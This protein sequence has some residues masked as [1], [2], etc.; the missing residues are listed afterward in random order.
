M[1]QQEIAKAQLEASMKADFTKTIDDER[2]RADE[3]MDQLTSKLLKK[4]KDMRRIHE[5]H[6]RQMEMIR[7]KLESSKDEQPEVHHYH[8]NDGCTLP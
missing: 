3:K 4:D 5:D 1:E 7:A 6:V 8:S 2:Q